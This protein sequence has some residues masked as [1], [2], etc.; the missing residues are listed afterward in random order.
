MPE[1]PYP[2]LLLYTSNE[3]NARTSL[4][5]KHPYRAPT[6]P[7]PTT[8]CACSFVWGLFST[9]SPVKFLRQRGGLTFD[10]VFF[11]ACFFGVA[12]CIRHQFFSS[13]YTPSR[14]ALRSIQLPRRPLR[15][16][17]N[18]PSLW[19]NQHK[20]TQSSEESIRLLDLFTTEGR[21]AG[22]GG[23]GCRGCIQSLTPIK[24]STP[25]PIEEH[26]SGMA[27]DNHA[28]KPPLSSQLS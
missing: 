7:P 24:W 23:A 13:A 26:D 4:L 22:R 28:V 9:K 27:E 8:P 12:K 10:F 18:S 5:I 21:K 3:K 6:P 25:W 15:T 2:R 1:G 14:R 19:Q 17:F 16:P 11:C 20:N